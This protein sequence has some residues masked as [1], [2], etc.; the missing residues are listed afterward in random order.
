MHKK[1]KMGIFINDTFG[2]V[3]FLYG[4]L[5]EDLGDLFLKYL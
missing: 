3:Q 5:P 2:F 1:K 4:Y